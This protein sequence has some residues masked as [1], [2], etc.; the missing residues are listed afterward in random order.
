MI[1]L[2]FPFW[3]LSLVGGILL[4]IYAAAR[5]DPVFMVGQA[6]GVFIYIRNIYFILRERK[7]I[8]HAK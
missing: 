2:S 5:H 1:K 4:F 6:S 7:E 8:V 3:I